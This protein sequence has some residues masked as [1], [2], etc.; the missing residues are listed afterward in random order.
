A[1]RATGRA[2]QPLLDD[3]ADAE[4][5][6]AVARRERDEL[7]QRALATRVPATTQA[8]V[9]RLQE[10]LRRLEVRARQATL[11]ARQ[12]LLDDITATRRLLEIARSELR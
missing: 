10:R 9:E 12:M 7:D 11:P 6:L 2:P 8:V 5:L 3:R 1:R 4:R